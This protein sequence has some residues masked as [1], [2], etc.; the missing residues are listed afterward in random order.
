[1]PSADFCAAIGKPYGFLSRDA[2]ASV[3]PDTTQTSRG[4]FDNLLRTTA[5]FTPMA[6]DGYG[7]RC[8]WPVRPTVTASYPISVRRLTH[9]LHASFRPR[10]ATTPLRFTLLH[11][12]QVG[13]GTSTPQTVKHARHNRD[14]GEP[15]G[16]APPTPPG[17]RVRTTAVRLGYVF[18]LTSEGIPRDLQNLPGSA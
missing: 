12:H 4:K 10:L 14:R 3:G 15:C 1:M 13:K 6:L 7:L 11:L 16:S 9:S 17:V 8:V 18:W 5:G 2:Y